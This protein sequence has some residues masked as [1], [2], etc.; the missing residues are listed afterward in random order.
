MRP[1]QL[2][3]FCPATRR[4]QRK[5]RLGFL[6]LSLLVV[7]LAGAVEITPEQRAFFESKI[8]PVLVRECYECHSEGAK[9][10]G[11]KLLLDTHP[12]MM[13]GGESGPAMQPKNPKASL[14][15]QALQ[16]EGLEMPPKRKLPE[17]VIRDFVSW[18][19]MGVPD[20]RQT[21]GAK[22]PGVS[23]AEKKAEL[24]SLRP[25]TNP[26]VPPVSGEWPLDPL[27]HF[28]LAKMGGLSP[29]RPAPPEALVRRL[30]VDLTGLP[31]TAED[32]ERF[33][34]D[35]RAR[36]RA[37]WEAWVDR[38]LDSPHYGERW[39]R[40]WLDIARY[41]EANGDDGLGR[42][43][44]FPHAWRYRDYVIDSLNR[45]TPYDRF[46]REQLAGDLLET[47][48]DAERDRNLV[49][50]GFLAL[51]A[52]PAVAMN[53]NFAMDVVADQITLVGSGV[54]GISV[55]CARCHDH[56]HDPI[57]L[58]D[59]TALAGIFKSTETLWGAAA[60]EGLSAPQTPL[61]PLAAAAWLPVPAGTKKAAKGKFN[62]P[63]GAPL[64]MGACESG[65]V[66]DCRVNI[67]GESSK[68]GE[69][70]P[71]GF[72]ELFPARAEPFGFVCPP[73]SGRLELAEW[74][75]NEARPLTA[76]VFVNRVW[77]HL[78]EEGLVRTPDD[79]GVFGDMPVQRELLDHLATRFVSEGWSI[80][81]L[82]RSIVLSRTY[83]MSSERSEAAARRDPEN[84]L[85]SFHARRRLDAESL[86][87]AMLVASGKLDRRPPVGS[88][89]AHQNV[90][91]NAMGNLHQPNF[92]RSV[93][94]LMLRSALP[95]ELAAF[96]LP[97]G[98]TV[99]GR[100]EVSTLPTQALFLFNNP[101]V[102]QQSLFLAE[103]VLAAGSDPREQV[104]QAY[105]CVF[106]RDPQPREVGAALGFVADTERDL[107]G[108]HSQPEQRR[109]TA[110]AAFCQTLLA[111]NEMRYTD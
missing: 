106:S 92:H 40:H 15:I 29:A 63:P 4:A 18:V 97:D 7:Q 111:S 91:I 9:K 108:V 55:G 81:K 33:V 88:A 56:K 82:I 80:K 62:Y 69:W 23:L 86:R 41:A 31:A 103:R 53:D 95:P 52:K 105:R 37:A 24:W 89:L 71:R 73:T 68:L 74:L 21:P 60:M 64:A 50:T 93:Y 6:G 109:V 101:F 59:Y 34:A 38:L 5:A 66:G 17:Q 107:E 46:L 58:R 43:P 48:S 35:Y 75:V 54:L 61:H 8:R 98:F 77:K 22:K 90:L 102:V 87:D 85:L 39:G 78:F 70:V 3:N 104:R 10:I 13:T 1:L 49:A 32:T 51:C 20:P 2:L 110:W 12:D 28:V 100:R 45:D 30:S 25:I 27:D 83:Q 14:I 16:Y 72:P 47:G 36:G 44:N 57:T 96:N 99:K 79:F 19:E 65:Q 84:R 67:G 76:R 94:Q 11:G 26:A 42:N